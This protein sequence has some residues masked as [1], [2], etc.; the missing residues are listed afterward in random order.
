MTP[1]FT[2]FFRNFFYGKSGS[3]NFFA[4]RM[5]GLRWNWPPHSLTDWSHQAGR[6]GP[7]CRNISLYLSCICICICHLVHLHGRHILLSAD[8]YPIWDCSSIFCVALLL[9]LLLIPSMNAPF[10]TPPAPDSS[11]IANAEK[12]FGLKFEYLQRGHPW[13]TS[14][15]LSIAKFKRC[16]LFMFHDKVHRYCVV[17]MIYVW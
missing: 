12:L 5:Y 10:W 13:V 9:I 8:F 14:D 2:H 1:G 7:G 15:S 4:F 16:L 11:G 17:I 3:A 6:I